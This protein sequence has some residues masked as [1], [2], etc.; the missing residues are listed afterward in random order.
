M[1]VNQLS[2]LFLLLVATLIASPAQAANFFHGEWLQSCTIM[3]EDDYIQNLI[4]ADAKTFDLVTFAYE[5]EGCNTAYL[6]FKHK[7]SFNETDTTVT[8]EEQ[9]ANLTAVVEKITYTS[10]TDEVTEALNMIEFCGESDWVTFREKTITGQTCGDY[11][12][13]PQNSTELLTIKT[14][15]KNAILLNKDQTPYT[16]LITE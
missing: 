16:K 11:K 10:L 12:A 7:Y 5:E 1:K 9:T 4:M 8:A 3:N 2:N 6:I 15:S 14:K 13:P